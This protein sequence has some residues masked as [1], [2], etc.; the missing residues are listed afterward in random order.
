MRLLEEIAEELE[1]GDAATSKYEF[2]RYLSDAWIHCR[3]ADDTEGWG[4]EV[5]V[6]IGEL[7]MIQQV[8]ELRAELDTTAFVRPSDFYR[9]QNGD[10][11]VR[12]PWTINDTCAATS[13]TGSNTILTN[14]RRRRKA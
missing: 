14:N 8:E 2:Q 9:F 4:T 11:Q 10:V 3:A 12:L 1:S 13:E 5:C 7:R 6:G